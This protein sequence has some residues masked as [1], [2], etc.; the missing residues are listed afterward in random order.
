MVNWRLGWSRVK[1]LAQQP[2]QWGRSYGRMA[3]AALGLTVATATPGLAV[4]DPPSTDF[5]D[6]RGHWSQ[7]CV[8]SLA[9]RNIVSGYPNTRYFPDRAISRAEFVDM[10]RRA[11]P[12][13]AGNLTDQSPMPISRADA[14]AILVS[15]IKLPAIQPSA[16]VLQNTFDDG[17]QVPA[18]VRE[19]V[20]IATEHRLVVS[21]PDI[22]QL[23]PNQAAT[24]AEA[25]SFVCQA[26]SLMQITSNVP[27]QYVAEVPS[28]TQPVVRT[29]TSEGTNVTASLSYEKQNYTFSNLQLTIKRGK[30]GY[31]H[32]PLLT[33]GGYARTMGFRLMDLDGDGEPEILIDIF[34]GIG[35]CC[36]YSL[37][38]GYV[39]IREEYEL[40]EKD[41]GYIG[42]FLKDFDQDGLP[43]FDSGD[44]RFM[45]QF[46][47]RY[48]DA[49]LPQQIWQYRNG[50]L[51]NVT[52]MYRQVV[53]SHT[54][55]LWQE[56]MNRRNSGD[57]AKGVLAAYIAN[58]YLVGEGEDG[59]QRVKESYLA[60]DRTR[61]FTTLQQFLR[62]IGYAP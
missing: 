35:R 19:Q 22:R 28:L 10:V 45:F 20:A 25:A 40:I 51:F 58:K 48:L 6:A 23:R 54:R 24:R 44:N 32:Q 33:K 52:R 60:S 62:G 9:S 61:Y 29:L 57:D 21:P 34:P 4:T 8:D 36:S 16:E 59:W 53:H 47:S 49:A 46:A 50:D 31:Y 2:Q 13:Q 43:E 3:V 7:L 41:W 56:Y 17:N 39:A 27:P 14:L 55:N 30:N 11:Y 38:Y 42:Y 5:Y 15:T 26:R 18:A 1:G 37:V 12:E